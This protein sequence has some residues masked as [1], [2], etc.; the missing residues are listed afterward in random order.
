M[1]QM[2]AMLLATTIAGSSATGGMPT[3]DLNKICNQLGTKDCP[4]VQQ[5]T[6]TSLEDLKQQLKEMGIQIDWNNCPDFNFPGV[7]IPKPDKPET[8]NPGT[9]KPETDKPEI[10]PP[11]TDQP[12][13]ESPD[14]TP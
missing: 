14:E 12:G 2:A 11:E 5:V 1:Y 13:T 10:T 7:D 6:G 3:A 8:D 4:I 9:N